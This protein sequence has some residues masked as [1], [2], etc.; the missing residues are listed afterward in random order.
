MNDTI[1]NLEL[2]VGEVNVILSSLGKHPFDE[3]SVLI[4]KIKR[5]GESQLKELSEKET[6]NA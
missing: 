5:Q 1:L 3:I 2:T 6:S 4:G